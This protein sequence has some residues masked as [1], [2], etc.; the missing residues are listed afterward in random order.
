VGRLGFP[1]GGGWSD[2]LGEGDL[3]DNVVVI[4]EGEGNHVLADDYAPLLP[5]AAGAGG[6]VGGR[7]EEWAGVGDGRMSCQSATKVAWLRGAHGRAKWRA[8][9]LRKLPTKMSNNRAVLGGILC[10]K[11]SPASSMSPSAIAISEIGPRWL[12]RWREGNIT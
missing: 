9:P 1:W 10:R 8:H 4:D 5:L 11:S 2:D 12:P 6:Q 3:V 7:A